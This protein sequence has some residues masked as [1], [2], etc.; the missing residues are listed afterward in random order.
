MNNKTANHYRSQLSDIF[1]RKEQRVFV[2]LIHNDA[3]IVINSHEREILTSIQRF[4]EEKYVIYWNYKENI[5]GKCLTISA[6]TCS[7]QPLPNFQDGLKDYYKEDYQK[8]IKMITDRYDAKSLT[9]DRREFYNSVK[10]SY[11]AMI[12]DNHIDTT[13]YKSVRDMFERVRY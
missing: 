1:N 8:R 12:N 2:G 3:D 5:L 11:D 7:N 9:T 4:L 10:Q 6:D 13:T